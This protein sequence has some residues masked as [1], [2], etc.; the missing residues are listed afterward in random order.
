[1]L[2]TRKR[3][4]R[5]ELRKPD[6]FLTQ[7]TR[8][9]HIFERHR[10]TI[11]L[12]VVALVVAGLALWGWNAYRTRQLLAASTRYQT[13]LQAYH[14]EEFEN[15]LKLFARVKA[16][17]GSIYGSLVLL[18]QAQSYLALKRPTEAILV[19]ED[20]IKRDP[21]QSFLK[22]T[23]FLNLGYAKESAGQC[24]D[25]VAAYDQAAQIT[26]PREEEA[27]L[28]EA[29][30]HAALGDNTQAIKAY[31]DYLARFPGTA[32]KTE[33]NILIDELKAKSK[34]EAKASEKEA[35]Q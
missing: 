15:A 32:R 20:L 18:Y 21:S 5:K 27:I 26:G 23:A 1:M 7:S 9:L 35:G 22:Q 14:D 8:V 6:Q 24:A 28:G 10:K 25:A 30:C 34:G 11:V 2:R 33:I 3:I 31:E 29:R 17:R 12:S 13:A 16:P 4:T 19:L